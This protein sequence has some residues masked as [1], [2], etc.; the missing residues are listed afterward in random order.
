MHIYRYYNQ[1]TITPKKA[2][3]EATVYGAV[4][5]C[6][7]H[8]STQQEVNRMLP[9]YCSTPSLPFALHRPP[10]CLFLHLLAR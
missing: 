3:A 7:E 6:E 8:D 9:T 10:N 5:R 1:A 4:Y 2:G